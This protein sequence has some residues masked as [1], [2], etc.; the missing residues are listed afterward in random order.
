MTPRWLSPCGLQLAE[1]LL[2]YDPS[3]RITAAQALQHP[4]FNQEEPPPEI[5]VGYVKASQ[6][7]RNASNGICFQTRD[8]GRR[9]ARTGDQAREGKKKEEGSLSLCA[10]TNV[11]LADLTTHR[12]M[13]LILQICSNSTPSHALDFM[14][15]QFT[16][17]KPLPVRC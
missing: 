17:T 15:N 2:D 6:P 4:Y 12:T 5:P 13:H 16:A 3:R 11:L 7:Q 9:V 1:Q 10:L 8:V 14:H